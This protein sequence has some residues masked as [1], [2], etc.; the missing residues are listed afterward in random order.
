[1]LAGV[2]GTMPTAVPGMSLDSIHISN[3][4]PRGEMQKQRR[5]CLN[6]TALVPMERARWGQREVVLSVFMDEE[7]KAEVV[8]LCIWHRRQELVLV[9]CGGQAKAEVVRVCFGVEP[10]EEGPSL[11]LDSGRSSP[12]DLTQ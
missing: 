12:F 3:R 10:K 7:D 1:M 6:Q 11:P 9:G 5:Y 2:I 4:V 8:W